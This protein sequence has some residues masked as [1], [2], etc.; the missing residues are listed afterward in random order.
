VRHAIA[1]GFGAGRRRA[2]LHVLALFAALD[3]V[4]EDVIDN[5]VAHAFLELESDGVE[6]EGK[7]SNNGDTSDRREHGP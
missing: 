6:V 4:I 2:V 7:V 5:G 3:T 1:V